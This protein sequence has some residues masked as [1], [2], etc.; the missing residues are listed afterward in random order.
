LEGEGWTVV[1]AENGRVGVERLSTGA[2]D[3]VLLDLMMPEM[4]GFEF[5]EEFRT[6]GRRSAIPVVVITA[7]DLTEDDLRRLNG[8]VERVVRKSGSGPQALL[9]QVR[10]LLTAHLA[11]TGG[12]ALDD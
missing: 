11:P 8:G 1:E 5:L 4:D 12:D 2:P 6:D 7:K 10:G 3:L 9:Q